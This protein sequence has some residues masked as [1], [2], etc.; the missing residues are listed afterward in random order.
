MANLETSLLDFHKA[1]CYF[2]AAIEIA[3]LVLASQA[4][5]SFHNSK[6]P[7]VFDILLALPLAL[8]GIVPIAFSL[9]CIALYCRLSW[10]I[11]LLSSVP[12]LL[13]T[14][15]LASTHIWL[16]RPVIDEAIDI[17]LFDRFREASLYESSST[18]L[19]CGPKSGNLR[20][21]FS[22]GSMK[23]S[24]IWL[25]YTYCIAWTLGCLLMQIPKNRAK[26]SLN[27]RTLATLRNSRVGRLAFVSRHK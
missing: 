22:K 20:N 8:N 4:Y 7:A 13:S 11:I 5:S 18:T 24:I 14:G 26:E 3:V 10:H 15:A 19:I 12:I 16:G 27:A 21:V 17:G 2:I 25:I 9:S 1:Q 6:Y 23:F